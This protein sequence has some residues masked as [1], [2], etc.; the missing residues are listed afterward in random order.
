MAS[1]CRFNASCAS[2]LR[3][4]WQPSSLFSLLHPVSACRPRHGPLRPRTP[5]QHLVPLLLASCALLVFLSKF[6]RAPCVTS[7][8][9]TT[10]SRRCRTSSSPC[11]C[12]SDFSVQFETEIASSSPSTTSPLPLSRVSLPSAASALL[13]LFHAAAAALILLT[14]VLLGSPLSTTLQLLPD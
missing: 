14:C 12:A 10:S 13:L 4:V 8:L 5:L 11:R 9:I 2:R 7:S 3:V 6:P 1:L